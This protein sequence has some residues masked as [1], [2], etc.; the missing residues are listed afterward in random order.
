MDADNNI[1][2]IGSIY[3]INSVFFIG[4]NQKLLTELF[5]FFYFITHLTHRTSCET[6]NSNLL[7][8]R[9]AIIIKIE[10]SDNMKYELIKNYNDNDFK[11]AIGIPREL[12]ELY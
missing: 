2:G 12:F 6:N 11:R 9:Y 5:L 10:G 8:K 4:T 7:L 3:R 1:A